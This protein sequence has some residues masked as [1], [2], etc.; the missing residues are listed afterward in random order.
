MSK[1]EEKVTKVKGF[2]LVN[3]QKVERALYGAPNS[4]NEMIGGIADADGTYDDDKLLAEYDRLGGLIKK[5]DDNVKTGSFYDFKKKQP[6]EKPTVDF[7]YRVNGQEVIV[8]AGK[9]LPGIIKATRILAS[10]ASKKLKNPN[11]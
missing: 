7:V 2:T 1:V 9:E 10:Q 6:K 4:E 3:A 11:K 8:P 5:G